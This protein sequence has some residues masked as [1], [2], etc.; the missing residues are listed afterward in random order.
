MPWRR[1]PS[2]QKSL[3]CE[4]SWFDRDQINNTTIAVNLAASPNHP[5]PDPSCFSW[6]IESMEAAEGWSLIDRPTAAADWINWHSL[7]LMSIPFAPRFNPLS[8][9]LRTE[10]NPTLHRC[11][12]RPRVVIDKLLVGTRTTHRHA[13]DSHIPTSLVY[14][15]LSPVSQH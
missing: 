10:S 14:T 12:F 4:S 13:D 9:I 11:A 15:R 6:A 3:V 2:T 5:Q 7:L 1:L 8:V